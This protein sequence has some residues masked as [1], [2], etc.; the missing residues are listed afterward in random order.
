M[1]PCLPHVVSQR[2][3]ALCICQDAEPGRMPPPLQA[4]CDYGGYNWGWREVFC[5]HHL[6]NSGLA[7]A[8]QAAS[9]GAAGVGLWLTLQAR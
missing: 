7:E 5:R 2:D 3:G 1:G 6:H 4:V 9:C 8:Q